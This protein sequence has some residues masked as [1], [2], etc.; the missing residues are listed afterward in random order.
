MTP[1]PDRLSVEVQTQAITNAPADAVSYN[2]C[3]SLNDNES[4]IDDR[5]VGAP[6]SIA[7][8][9]GNASSTGL[10]CRGCGQASTGVPA[11]VAGVVRAVRLAPEARH[12]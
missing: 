5:D 4:R 9:M 2:Y 8:F 1:V 7:R 11:S 10:E 3:G 12:G 6:G